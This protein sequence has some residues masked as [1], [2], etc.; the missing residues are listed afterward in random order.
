[1]SVYSLALARKTDRQ[2]DRHTETDIAKKERLRQEG[3]RNRGEVT[4]LLLSGARSG[5]SNVWMPSFVAQFLPY[6]KM[7]TEYISS[8]EAVVQHL[9]KLRVRAPAL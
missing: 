8:A 4:V 6:L 2:T 5:S 1:M 9:A 7:Y 3:E